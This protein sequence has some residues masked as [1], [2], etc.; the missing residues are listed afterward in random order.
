MRPSELFD[1]L[2]RTFALAMIAGAISVI[3]SP[4]IGPLGTLAI[5][6]LLLI[7][8]GPLARVFYGRT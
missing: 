7:V 8:S 6:I 1:V 2:I 3:L 5:G 4:A